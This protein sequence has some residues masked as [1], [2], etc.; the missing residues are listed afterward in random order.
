MA[1]L[2]KL[3]VLPTYTF[4]I[5]STGEELKYRP[6]LHKE[7]KVLQM[8]RESGDVKNFIKVVKDTIKACTYD[9]FDVDNA[10]SFDIEELFLRIRQASIGETV[11][12]TL[13][14]QNNITKE[15]KDGTS[16]EEVCRNAND[17][18]ID[19]SKIRID[20]SKLNKEKLLVSLT[21]DVKIEMMYPGIDTLQVIGSIRHED[22]TVDMVDIICTCV[23]SVVHGEEV[24]L[25]KELQKGELKNFI[26]NLTSQQVEK[27]M[28]VIL[29]MPTIE[30]K[31]S[32]KCKKCGQ[33]IEFEFRGL[34]DFFE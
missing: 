31:V 4:V 3:N 12:V 21:D 23:K 24:Y 10:A 17:I 1:T 22:E 9:E 20:T 7:E 8:A 16:I 19:L 18:K 14:C 13:I 32:E 2:D 34:Y 33:K 25:A 29:E 28:N 30:Y 11:T 6:F 15:K 26:N 5:P 27:L